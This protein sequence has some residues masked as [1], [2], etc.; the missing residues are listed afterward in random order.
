MFLKTK[1]NYWYIHERLLL[2]YISA[3]VSLHMCF[4]LFLIHFWSLECLTLGV[5]SWC[6]M[7]VFCFESS[8]FTNASEKSLKLD[9]KNASLAS[10]NSILHKFWCLPTTC[11][12]SSI[13]TP[14]IQ[15]LHFPAGVQLHNA[16]EKV[17]KFQHCFGW[18]LL[19]SQ[20]LGG[21]CKTITH[22]KWMKFSLF[23][24]TQDKW[25]NDT[26]R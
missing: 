21:K 26:W 2:W 13:L 25:S 24:N 8:L 19:E 4:S 12:I 18:K 3:L 15:Q 17:S 16:L 20:T 1:C 22:G 14:N 9:V 6:W 7:C 10:L 23:G 11:M 5:L